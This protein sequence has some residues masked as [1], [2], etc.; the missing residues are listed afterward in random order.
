MD[1]DLDLQEKVD[2]GPL[3]KVD[4]MPKFT[5]LVKN[6][7]FDKFEGADFKYNN[8]FFYIWVQKYP[9]KAIQ[10]WSQF[11]YYLTWNNNGTEDSYNGYQRQEEGRSSAIG[12]LLLT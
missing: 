4:L 3:E 2:P 8:V 6:S 11:F 5:I 10:F 7:F 9:N 12:F 1:L